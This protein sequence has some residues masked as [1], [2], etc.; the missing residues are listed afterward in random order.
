MTRQANYNNYGHF[1]RVFT[2]TGAII[3]NASTIASQ[4]LF[5]SQ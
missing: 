5:A 1:D 4:D 2:L 3:L